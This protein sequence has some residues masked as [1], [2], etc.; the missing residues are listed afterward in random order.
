MDIMDLSFR[1]VDWDHIYPTP[2]LVSS[3][4]ILRDF[5]FIKV[6]QRLTSHVPTKKGGSF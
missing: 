3:F 4:G 5:P 1:L 2:F 6:Y